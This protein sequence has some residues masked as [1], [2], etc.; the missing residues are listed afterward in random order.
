MPRAAA[1]QGPV[2]RPQRNPNPAPPTVRDEAEKNPRRRRKGKGKRRRN[3]K[4]PKISYTTGAIIGAVLGSI[5]VAISSAAKA[6]M[7]VIST[8]AGE[9]AVDTT[10]T[11]KRALMGALRG[12]AVG[13]AV[14][15]GATIVAREL[16]V[17]AAGRM[18]NPTGVGSAIVLGSSIAA[19]TLAVDHG[20]TKAFEAA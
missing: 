4:N 11:T 19:T 13:L 18:M 1:I 15:V 12:A 6:P 16:K 8:D 10:S 7:P 14:G 20:M 2:H 9:F 3:P 17:G 5:G